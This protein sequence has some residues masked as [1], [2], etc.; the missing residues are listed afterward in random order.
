MFGIAPHVLSLFFFSIDD[1]A[2]RCL[3]AGD[4]RGLAGYHAVKSVL[5]NQAVFLFATRS[6]I[7]FAA[8]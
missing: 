1:S 6:Y 2:W 4:Y 7:I 3:S 5:L 8:F